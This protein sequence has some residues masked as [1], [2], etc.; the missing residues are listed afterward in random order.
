MKLSE[1]ICSLTSDNT[2]SELTHML[3]TADAPKRVEFKISSWGERLIS[4]DGVKGDININ[5]IADKF[6]CSVPFKHDTQSTPQERL[7]C[8]SMR[9][10]L[11][12]LYETSDKE[13]A[14]FS[15][16]KYLVPIRDVISTNCLRSYI[17]NDPTYRDSDTPEFTPFRFSLKEFQKM[18]PKQEPS[19][20]ETYCYLGWRKNKYNHYYIAT[21][22]MVEAVIQKV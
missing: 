9:N 1:K 18:W 20:K 22:E 3:G 11:I 19:Y 13:L 4:V 8:D 15:I 6:L 21:R 2:V 12:A 5:K 10:R 17:Y 16:Y 7:L 14:K